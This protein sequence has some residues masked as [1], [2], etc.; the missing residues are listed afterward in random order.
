MRVNVYIRKAERDE[1]REHV[2]AAKKARLSII[3]YFLKIIRELR[4]NPPQK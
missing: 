2:R 1:Y 4:Q 3:A